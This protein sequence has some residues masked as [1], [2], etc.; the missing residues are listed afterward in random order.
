[1]AFPRR[2]PLETGRMARMTR[3]R[4]SVR[5]RGTSRSYCAHE[6]PV[7]DE[8]GARD[9]SRRKM[10]GVSARTRPRRHSRVAAVRASWR[11]SSCDASRDRTISS[12]PRREG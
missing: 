1:M 8:I 2:D 4:S 5:A 12:R 10:R 3:T 9:P 7:C 11:V 6:S